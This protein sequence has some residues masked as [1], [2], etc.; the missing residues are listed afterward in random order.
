[1]VIPFYMYLPCFGGFV[2][3]VDKSVTP[4]TNHMGCHHA[5]VFGVIAKVGAGLAY[6]AGACAW[7][8]HQ[9]HGDGQLDRLPDFNPLVM[10]EAIVRF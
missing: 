9:A 4:L 10:S 2:A 6:F 5:I 3:L 8:G 1:M 7:V